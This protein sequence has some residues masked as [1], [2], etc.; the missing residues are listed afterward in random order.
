MGALAGSLVVFS[1]ST[2]ALWSA[3]PVGFALGLPAVCVGCAAALGSIA[4]A[5]AGALL[6]ERLR[7]GPLS[8][9]VNRATKSA[10]GAAGRLASRFGVVGVGL[11]GPAITG[12][13]VAALLG[14]AFGLGRGPLLLWL[15]IG[16]LLWS[17]ALTLI[18]A[19]GISLLF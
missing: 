7:V 19:L 15:S 16:I 4:G 10:S 11:L 3:I 6:G 9:L 14:R 13:V 8:S 17:A 2:I 5:F 1:L 18:N 12:A